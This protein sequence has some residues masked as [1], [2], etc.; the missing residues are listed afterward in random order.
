[1]ESLEHILKRTNISEEN[2]D[3]SSSIKVE[4]PVV[5]DKCPVCKGMGWITP[6]VPYGHTDFGKAVACKCARK[7]LDTNLLNRLERYSNLG[8]LTNHTFS[9]LIE[10]GRSSDPRNQSL[11]KRVLAIVKAYAQKPDGWLVLMGTSGCGKTHL[12]AAIAN[13]VIRTGQPALFIVVPDLLDHLRSTFSP[14]SE[15]TYDELFN[16]IKNA[17]LLILDDLGTQSSTPWSEEKLFQIINHRFNS[18]LPTVFT[19]NH[20]VIDIPERFRTRL[21]DET[22]SQVVVVCEGQTSIL[23]SISPLQLELLRKMSFDNFDPKRLNLPMVQRDNLEMAFRNAMKFAESPEGWLVLQGTHGCG[24][25]HLAVAIANYRLQ[26]GDLVEFQIVPDFLDHLRTTFSP[27]KSNV[28]Y[29]SLFETVKKAPLLIL[30]DLGAQTSTPWA[31]E[32]LYQVINYRYNDRLPTVITT[33]LAA[34]EI[35]DRLCSRM[36]DARL[37]N[38]FYIEAPDYRIDRESK[39]QVPRTRRTPYA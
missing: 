7:D 8:P 12:A 16:K 34:E 17:P 30:D 13:H 33:T 4:K 36:L 23:D 32:K 20:K 28:T 24:K 9:S 3:T 5:D 11:F 22:L 35:E 19:T 39:P 21:C 26:R 25:T 31:Q 10:T 14:S 27:E 38:V 2:T 37:S 18:R 6:D 15:I 1:M 29:D